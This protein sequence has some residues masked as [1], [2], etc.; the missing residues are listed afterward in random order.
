MCFSATA[1]FTASAAIGAAGVVSLIKAKEPEHKFFAS[2]PLI[3]SVQQFT[4]GFVWLSSSHT[5]LAWL[6]NPAMYSFLVFAQVVWPVWVPLSILF[7]EKDER[8]RLIFSMLLGLG[9]SVAMYLG[10]ALIFLNVRGEIDCSHIRYSID[11]PAFLKWPSNIL[12][13]LST[14]LSPLVSR[15]RGIRTMG[16]MLGIS[17][18]MTDVFMRIYLVSVWCFFAATMSV[19][20]IFIVRNTEREG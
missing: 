11:H 6:H 8:R 2:I 18:I 3:F 17:Y 4:E 10:C 16:L 12:Y 15:N 5:E 7:I 1:S 13:G 9:I 14:V 19:M 20:V